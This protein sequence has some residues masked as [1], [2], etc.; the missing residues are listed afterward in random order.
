MNK[1][2]ELKEKY[3]D[4][5]D[6]EAQRGKMMLLT[7]LEISNLSK[8][9]QIAPESKD[10]FIC[11]ICWMVVTQPM[12]CEGC[13]TLFC[14]ACIDSWLKAKVTCPK[15]CKGKQVLASQAASEEA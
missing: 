6:Y 10:Y 9:S 15:M 11:E 4:G 5:L 13:S 12:E 1:R 7:N 3:P 8:S 14:K 2:T